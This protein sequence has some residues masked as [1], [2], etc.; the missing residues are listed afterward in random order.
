MAVVACDEADLMPPAKQPP[1]DC[2][3][4]DL[5]AADVRNVRIRGERVV[6]SQ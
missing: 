5:S 6:G 3:D 2:D 1:R 4:L